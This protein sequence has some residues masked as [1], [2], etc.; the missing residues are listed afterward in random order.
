MHQ[1]IIRVDK[2]V[3]TAGCDEVGGQEPA[4]F[5][6]EVKRRNMFHR[7]NTLK[8]RGLSY[9]FNQRGVRLVYWKL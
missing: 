7:P 4:V 1:K 8:N 2:R 5:H 6:T 9:T 3:D